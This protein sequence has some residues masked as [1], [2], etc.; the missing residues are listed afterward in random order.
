M[1]LKRLPTLLPRRPNEVISTTAIKA[2]I[3]PYS[4]AVAPDS[5]FR[6]FCINFFNGLFLLTCA[7][8]MTS[9]ERVAFLHYGT[10]SA[11]P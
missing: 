3:K 1:L 7:R 6:N 2:A 4:I 9:T 10:S 5:P 8:E 11:K